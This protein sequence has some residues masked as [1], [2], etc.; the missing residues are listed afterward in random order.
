MHKYMYEIYNLKEEEDDK[1]EKY[2]TMHCTLH[3]RTLNITN[4]QSDKLTHK[5]RS[6]LHWNTKDLQKHQI[7]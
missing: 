3:I 1:E 5:F 7:P 6:A 2:K 4:K